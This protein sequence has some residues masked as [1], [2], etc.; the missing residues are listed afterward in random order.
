MISD[1][2]VSNKHKIIGIMLV[3]NEETYIEKVLG[4]IL[5]FCDKIIVA[6]NQSTDLTAE[7]VHTLM[8][9]HGDKLEYHAIRHPRESHDLI[10][11]YAGENVWI[12]GVDGDELYDPKGLALLKSGIN[13]NIYDEYWM[14]LGNALNCVELDLKANIASGYLA[15]PCRSMTKLYNFSAI[16]AWPGPC[17]ERLHGGKV[18]FKAGFDSK[19]RYYL[20]DDYSWSE[21]HFRCLHLC[22]LP[23]TSQDSRKSGQ[24]FIRKNIA[25]KLAENYWDRIKSSIYRFLGIADTSSWKKEKYMRGDLVTVSV[26][27][28]LVG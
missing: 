7:R 25:D 23:R 16:E 11:S 19:K 6:D 12:F 21:S 14:I 1:P 22:F 24:L 8:K 26:K 2:V 28:F 4:N 15:P 9:L 27:D 10:S 3:R 20:H 18:E 5:G 13:N 17:S